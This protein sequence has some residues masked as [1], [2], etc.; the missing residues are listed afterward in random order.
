M[1][2][3]SIMPSGLVRYQHSGHLHFIAFSCFRRQPLLQSR[4]GYQVFEQELEKVRARHGF[5][6]AGFVLMPDHVH[7]LV[8]EPQSLQLSATLQV[9]KQQV[10]RKLKRPCEIRFWQRRYYDFTVCS[11]QKRVEKLRYMH[12]NPVR[13]GLVKKPED[14]PWSSFH[15]SLTGER[16]TVEIESRWAAWR[17]EKPEA[18]VRPTLRKTG[19]G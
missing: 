15:H 5:L 10:S 9:L 16:G 12:R 11:H 18:S 3:L 2:H 8:S 6:V 14:W 17:R 13:R 19:E 7:L 4:T 1:Y